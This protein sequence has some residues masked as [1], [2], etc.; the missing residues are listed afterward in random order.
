M[1]KKNFMPAW[2][3]IWLM[4]LFC[5]LLLYIWNADG[6]TLGRFLTVLSFAIGEG[7]HC[8]LW[9]ETSGIPHPALL[10]IP[11]PRHLLPA[12]LRWQQA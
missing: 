8:C 6:S 9:D 7:R 2:L 11:H 4:A 5:E 12:A 1:K 3:Y 10:R